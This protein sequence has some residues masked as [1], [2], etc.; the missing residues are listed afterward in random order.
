MRVILTLSFFLLTL[1]ACRTEMLDGTSDP[2]L[3][4]VRGPVPDLAVS[5]DLGK[6]S[7]CKSLD[8]LACHNAQG[9]IADYCEQCSCTPTF[10]GC[11]AIGAGKIPCP[12]LGCPQPLCCRDQSDCSM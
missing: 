5:S 2:D 7:A 11:R 4:V 10:V 3:G 9:C 1:G 12:G 6:A 8:E